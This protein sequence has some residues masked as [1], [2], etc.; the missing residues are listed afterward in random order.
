MHVFIIQF[1]DG[2]TMGGQTARAIYEITLREELAKVNELT[3]TI[4]FLPDWQTRASNKSFFSMPPEGSS[5][6]HRADE[7]VH[8]SN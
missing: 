6:V 2:K 4:M 1:P 7:S 5:A 8:Y 3:S